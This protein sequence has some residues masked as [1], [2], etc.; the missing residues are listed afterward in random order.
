LTENDLAKVIVDA[1]FKVHTTL[2]PGLLITFGLPR[3]EDGI[4]R[5]IN[6]LDR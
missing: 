1:A 6:G 3:T 5:V 4:T 2:G